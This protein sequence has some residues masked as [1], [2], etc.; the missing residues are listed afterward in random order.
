MVVGGGGRTT[1]ASAPARNGGRRG[2]R[3]KP[4]SGASSRG[5]GR[6][7]RSA[8]C[9]AHLLIGSEPVLLQSG[10]AVRRGRSRPVAPVAEGE[11][12]GR[13]LPRVSFAPGQA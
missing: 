1:G 13:P 5:T 2:Q 4:P 7:P 11:D 6:A 9:H 12:N 8:R 3:R 10:R